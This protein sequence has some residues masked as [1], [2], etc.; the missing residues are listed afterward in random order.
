MFDRQQILE[1][2]FGILTDD[3][4]ALEATLVRP[5]ALLDSRVEAVRAWLPK[6]PLTMSSV[7]PAAR[8]EVM[9]AGPAST[10]A[11]L[12]FD[13][14]GTGESEGVPSPEGFAI[15]VHSAHEWAKERFGEEIGFHTLGFPDL[16]KA[17][18][19]VNMPLRPGVM[20]EL[21][22]YNAP[23]ASQGC[24]LYLSRYS[25]FDRQDDEICH[26]LAAGNYT[27]YGGDL[28]RYLL[29]AAPLTL[30]TFVRDSAAVAA[31]LSQPLYLAARSQA[32]GPALIAAAFTPSVAGVIVT[33]SAQEGLANS[34][35]FDRSTPSQW[36]LSGPIKKLAPRPV[37]FLWN[38]EEGVARSSE[39]LRALY[40][41]AEKPRLWGVVPAVDGPLLL[42]ALTWLVDNSVQPAG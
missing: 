9:A 38:Q 17:N 8:R 12:V 7:L 6:Y 23:G 41:M 19:L 35:L 18:H 31:R 33:G 37:V 22:C 34:F 14:R 28:M 10:I 32:A 3:G 39:S 13:L 30:D 40:Q 27:V 11:N 15:D 1:E 26:A 36:L 25:D 29:L 21:Y 24:V 4:L 16:G 20:V 5:R 2:Y 42:N